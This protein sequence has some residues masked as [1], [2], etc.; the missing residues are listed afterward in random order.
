M[1]SFFQLCSVGAASRKTGHVSSLAV[2]DGYRRHGIARKLM[3]ILHVQV[4]PTGLS[5]KCRG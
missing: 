3:E 5:K 4:R 2:L 1:S